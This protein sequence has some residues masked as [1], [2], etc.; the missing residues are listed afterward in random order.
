VNLQAV[1]A[2][3]AFVRLEPL[4]P[5]HRDDLRAACEAD[6]EIWTS[7]YPISWAGEHF[8]P[9]WDRL[10]G[11]VAAGRYI[12][13]AVLVGGRC[14][15][16]TSYLNIDRL[17]GAA[18][19][20]GTY[21]RPDLRGGPINPAAKRLMMANAF[22]AGA[23]RVVFRVDALN[24]RS[25]AA[26]TKLGA[27]LD[28]VMRQDMITWTGRIRDTAVYSVLADEWPIVRERLDERLAAFA[29]TKFEGVTPHGR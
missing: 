28:G 12:A 27:H 1:A 26:V 18:E 14:G 22:A 11:E 8:D 15:G 4:A 9:S 3:D 19:I 29:A 20:G 13:H 25:R 10:A 5:A 2:A 21:Y 24:A 16:M 17:N 6:A 7:L 23:R